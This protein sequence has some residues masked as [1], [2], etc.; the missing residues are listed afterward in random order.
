MTSEGGCFKRVVQ[1]GN[2]G[3]LQEWL[4]NGLE[5]VLATSMPG[6]QAQSLSFP[7]LRGGLKPRLPS[8]AAQA[9][10]HICTVGG[11]VPSPC[12]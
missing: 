10:T 3:F 7:Y 12:S 1:G 6:H 9:Q 4:E 8:F 11:A 5:I 2:P